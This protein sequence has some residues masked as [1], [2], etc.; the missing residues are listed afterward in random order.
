MIDKAPRR[1]LFI[2]GTPRSGTT[3]TCNLLNVHPDILIGIERYK[4]IYNQPDRADEIGEGLFETGRFTDFRPTDS[5]IGLKHY[6]TVDDLAR[7]S[8]AATVV[9]DKLPR[10]YA[11][12]DKMTAAFPGAR[13]IYMLRDPVRVASSWQVRADKERDSWPSVNDSARAVDEW[14]KANELTL[15][16]ARSNP[17]RLVVVPY[18]ELYSGNLQPVTQLQVWIGVSSDK[19][20]LRYY[21]QTCAPRSRTLA[22][23]PLALTAQQEEAINA[24]ARRDL[25]RELEPYFLSHIA[26]TTDLR[27]QRRQQRQ[28]AV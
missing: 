12:Y 8:G 18:E 26:A 16:F 1:Y 19:G 9:G 3:E 11:H 21:R 20:V 15:A 10:I 27:E 23:K 24:T 6:R 4:Y 7:H 5:N 17:G 25:V 2:C 22:K 28:G 14:N 13:F